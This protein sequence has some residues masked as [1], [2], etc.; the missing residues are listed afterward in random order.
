MAI[1]SQA[2]FG[3]TWSRVAGGLPVAVLGV[4]LGC[5]AHAAEPAVATLTGP[6]AGAGGGVAFA[7]AAR[8]TVPFD[9]GAAG[10]VEEEYLLRG[11]ARVLDWPQQAGGAPVVL[12]EGPYVTRVL[13]R[14][15]AQ[16]RR[17]SGTVIVEPYNPSAS[18]DLPIMWA[19][20][21]PQ[22]VADG[23]AWVGVTIK[24]V[25]LR[26]LQKFDPVR[27]ADLSFANPRAGNSCDAAS[28]NPLSGP[29]SPADE[30]GLAWDILTQ[31]G[32][33]LKGE[34]GATRLMPWPAQRLYMTGQSQS[35]AYAR[36]WATLFG[37]R[38][39][40]PDGKPLYAG[41]LYSGSPP[42]QVPL[43]QCRA[44]L[45]EGDPRLITPPV[46]VPVI[47]LFAEG[48]LGTNIVSRRPDS[49]RAP[50]L[51]RRYEVAG[52]AHVDTW[53]LRSLPNAEDTVRAG[54]REAG[55]TPGCTPDGLPTSDFPIRH[56]FNASWRHLDRWVRQGRAPPRAAPLELADPRGGLPP[57]RLFLHDANGNARGGVRSVAIDVPLTRWVGAKQGSLNCMFQGYRLPLAEGRLAEL[58]PTQAD[59]LRQVRRRAAALEREGWLTPQDRRA[60]IEEAR[61]Q[62]WPPGDPRDP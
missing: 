56:A 62:S 25:A 23:M 21:H 38:E 44:D 8:Q 18:V 1:R 19:Q 49:D 22:F 34:G 20:S 46:G 15:P 58:Y 53:E 41:Y 27:Y 48:D 61:R 32:H 31:L 28:M 10:Y 60:L 29:G 30:T 4:L 24:P 11:R 50:D 26:A 59:Y 45:P 12:A 2:G 39:N 51:F 35:A 57:E 43:H 14:R 36:T 42:W 17:F 37:A 47:E 16:R 40:G 54:G 55:S 6:L 9:L 3:R 5:A 7:A 33:A 52:A 13:V